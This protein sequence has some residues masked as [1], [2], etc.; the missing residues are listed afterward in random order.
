M[1]L[2]LNII[3]LFLKYFY[4]IFTSKPINLEA[5]DKEIITTPW[6]QHHELNEL[7]NTIFPKIPLVRSKNRLYNEKCSSCHGNARQG[8]YQ[9]EQDGD[10]FYPPLTGITLT[11]KYLLS[12]TKAE[13]E[14]LHEGL[15]VSSDFTEKEYKEPI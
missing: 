1:Q 10:L 4:E 14:W 13:F 7:S 9:T 15:K 12:D 6:A 2:T 8:I 5:S 3:L 11:Q